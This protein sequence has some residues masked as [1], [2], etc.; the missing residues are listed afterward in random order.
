MPHFK[1]EDWEFLEQV[2][3]VLRRFYD[4]TLYISQSEP[5]ISYAVP[6]YYD[7]HDLVNDAVSREGEFENLHEDI[8]DAV[9]SALDR[10]TKYYDF[11]D[12]QDIYYIALILNP[13]YKTRLL[14]Q[15]LGDSA[16]AVIQHIKEVL[17]RSTLRFPLDQPHPRLGRVLKNHVMGLNVMI[18]GSYDMMTP[19]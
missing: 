12:G 4:H 3:T 18:M 9:N 2:S 13:R 8:A 19:P 15:E 10:Y 7:L 16:E 11:M 1:K 14:E 5:Q 17:H 6:I